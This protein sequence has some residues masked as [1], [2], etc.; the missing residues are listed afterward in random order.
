MR[1][2]CGR[3]E[4]CSGKR[5]RSDAP[6]VSIVDSKATRIKLQGNRCKYILFLCLSSNIFTILLFF[7]FVASQD[8]EGG[9][10]ILRGDFASCKQLHTSPALLFTYPPFPATD[11]SVHLPSIPGS[12]LFIYSLQVHLQQNVHGD[13]T[14]QRKLLQNPQRVKFG[15]RQHQSTLHTINTADGLLE[16]GGLHITGRQ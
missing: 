2:G 6:E 10:K 4:G 3:A 13:K 5:S 11:S 9:D 8:E 7:R 1:N 12:K 16:I 15:A 14:A